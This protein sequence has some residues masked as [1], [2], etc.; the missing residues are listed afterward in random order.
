[1]RMFSKRDTVPDSELRDYLLGRTEKD[2]SERLDELSVCDDAVA[3]RLSA[4]ENDL[5]DAYVRGELGG[6]DLRLF[7]SHYLSTAMR[8]KKVELSRVLNAASVRAGAE[9]EDAAL[10]RNH[11]T[12]DAEPA[13]LRLGNLWQDTNLRWAF[14]CALLAVLTASTTWLAISDY[15]LRSHDRK[16][17][18][19]YD[20]L[21][22]QYHQLQEW[23]GKVHPQSPADA[24][25]V[26][27]GQSEPVTQVSSL[28]LPPPLRGA[29]SV[30]AVSVAAG[31][32][33]FQLQL[34]LESDDF[35]KYQVELK[36]L[37]GETSIWRSQSVKSSDLLHRRVVG[38]LIPAK[39]VKDTRSYGADV[40][41]IAAN[42]QRELIG[43]YFFQIVAAIE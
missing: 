19:A 5:V 10:N 39:T 15:R 30:P 38:V 26:G 8:R 29:R 22:K 21:E 14:V 9:A 36:S 31:D 18:D 4:A 23:A 3:D 2:A 17:R 28:F 1:M 11:R 6:K 41:G 20:A 34:G 42:G 40:W 24:I 27:T 33:W 16:A 7:E 43:T 13:R 35:P 32:K 12:G 37:A 25:Q